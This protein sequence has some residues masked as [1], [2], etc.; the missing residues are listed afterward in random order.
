MHLPTVPTRASFEEFERRT[1]ASRS[2]HVLAVALVWSASH[3]EIG[4][5]VLET[6]ETS[7]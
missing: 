2:S 4:S 5:R 7:I 6:I 3:V 1:V